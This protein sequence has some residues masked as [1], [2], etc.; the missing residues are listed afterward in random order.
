MVARTFN[1]PPCVS[2]TGTYALLTGAIYS[3]GSMMATAFFYG[4]GSP[5]GVVGWLC[6]VFVGVTDGGPGR[7]SLDYALIGSE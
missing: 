6:C 3:R 4:E 1:I 2:G 5:W 7:G